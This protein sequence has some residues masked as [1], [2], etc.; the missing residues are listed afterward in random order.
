LTF[1]DTP[2][3]QSITIG[4]PPNAFQTYLVAYDET[5]EYAAEI[6]WQMSWTD[7]FNGTVGG[8]SVTQNT[9]PPDPSSGT[10]GITILNSG[11]AVPGDLNAD[12]VVNCADLD[13][14]RASF[15]QKIGQP[16]IDPR[17]DVNGDGVVN[18]LD[19]S[20]VAR[21]MPAGTTCPSN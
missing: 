4:G 14:V 16:N 12:G 13:I 6:L 20:T 18:V 17:A 2:A 5:N 21:Q 7:S 8:I 10:G 1:C 9:S 19:L 11:A 15:G 3:D